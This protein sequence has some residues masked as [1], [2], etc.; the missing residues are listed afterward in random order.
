MKT[1]QHVAV[2][3]TYAHKTD[4]S[5]MH[6]DIIVPVDLKDEDK[7]Y[8]FGRH[9]LKAKGY[10]EATINAERCQFCHIEETSEEITKTISKQ[11]FYILEMDD[12][13]AKLPLNANKRDMVFHLKAHF[14]QYRFMN[15]SGVPIEEIQQLLYKEK[16]KR[17]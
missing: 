6:F 12:I 14:E 3:D 5:V 13:P 4:G 10:P 11:G 15:F 9:Y 8:E 2:W 1:L 16:I 7:I 17:R